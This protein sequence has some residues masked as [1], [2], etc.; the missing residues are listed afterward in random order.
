MLFRYNRLGN[1]NVNGEVWICIMH[2]HAGKLQIE[3]FATALKVMIHTKPLLEL[4]PTAR[5]STH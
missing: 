2:H 5:K 1:S 4:S 3:D